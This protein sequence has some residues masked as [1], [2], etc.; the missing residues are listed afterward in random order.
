MTVAA[1]R[2]HVLEVPRAEIVGELM[3]LQT[4]AT[5]AIT[6]NGAALQ[7]VLRL[8]PGPWRDELQRTHHDA[9]DALSALRE[10]IRTRTSTYEHAPARA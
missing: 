8:P 9:H 10:A 1:R 6:A 2:P 4:F 5:D 3:D 7:L